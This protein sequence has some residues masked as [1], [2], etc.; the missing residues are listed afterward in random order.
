MG[1]L[2][3]ASVWSFAVAVVLAVG[4]WLTDAYATARTFQRFGSTV[5]LR[6][7]CLLRGAT[8]VFQA[9]NPAL[10][11]A[12]L[13]VVMH[14]RG[15]PISKT[16]VV[17]ALLNAVFVVQITLISGSGLVAGAAP[18]GGMSGPA[19]GVALGL[20]ALYLM[21]IG[22]RPAALARRTTFRGLL[23]VGLAG[24][25]WA[26][27]YRIPNMVIMI[28][29]QVLFIRCFGIEL[30]LMVAL[31]YLPAVMLVT[32]IPIS[33]QGLGPAQVAQVAFFA[34]YVPGERGA[35]EAAVLAW[36][37]GS[38]VLTSLGSLLVGV[39]CLATPT[40]RRSLRMARGAAGEA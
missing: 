20:V 35:A 23:D 10:G 22:L 7:T 40:G 16:L 34:S 1:A 25:G 14:R 38:T 4:G 33:V 29:C 2:G 17:V 27:L 26:F 15:T 8:L 28:G 11:Q 32:G 37:L 19:V 5:T 24:H 30:P 6:E 13:M 31:L 36:G 9:I 3:R 12:A 39:A 21:V 18:P